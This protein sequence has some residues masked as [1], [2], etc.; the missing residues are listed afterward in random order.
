MAVDPGKPAHVLVVVLYSL[1]GIA[2]GLVFW[3][4][5]VAYGV[6]LLRDGH[7]VAGTV[8]TTLGAGWALLLA[9]DMTVP[10]MLAGG[11]HSILIFVGLAKDP[12]EGER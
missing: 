8:V 10:G 1:A 4:G 12:W 6:T 2:V 11:V 3:L 5:P 9:R 7:D